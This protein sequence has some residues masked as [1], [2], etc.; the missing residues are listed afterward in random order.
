MSAGRLTVRACRRCANARYAAYRRLA[1]LSALAI[2]AV[3]LTGC[4]S[5]DW[6]TLREAPRTPLVERLNL[7][8][9][10]G[11][12]PTARTMQFLRR[13]DLVESLDG[14]PRELLGQIQTILQRD[15]SADGCHAFAELAYIG[16]TKT[17][18][19][20]DQ[21]ALDLYGASVA[22]SY[23]YLFDPRF[24]QYRNPYD[25]QFRE[26]C[27]LYNGALEGALRLVKEKGTLRPGSTH[28]I[29]LAG[30]SW[31]VTVAVRNGPWR[32]DEFDRFEFVSDYEIKGLQNHY[33]TYGLGV[34]LAAVRKN[35]NQPRPADRYFPPVLAFPMT[36]FL[37]LVPSETG[38]DGGRGVRHRAVLELYD[39][40]TSADIVVADRRVPL[41]TDLSTPLAYFLNDPALAKIDLSTKGL[42]RPEEAQPLTGLYMLEPY[43]PGKIPVLFVHGLWSSPITWMEMF[44][45]L[46]GSP[47]V[48]QHYQFWFYLYPSGQPFWLSATRMRN[49]LMEMRAT[50]DPQRIAP[51]LDQM[52]LVGH[53]MGGLV[54]RMQT[55]DS[56]NDFWNIVSDKPFH[57]VKAEPPVREDLERLFFFEPNQSIRRVVTI[58]T[59]HR[60]SSF[61][62]DTT[63]WVSAKLI[64]LPAILVQ[65][66]QQ[67]RQDNPELFRPD[68][69]LIEVS[70]SIDSLSPDCPILPVMLSAR[71]APWTQYHNIVGRAP[72]RGVVG[73]F[74][75]DGD[76]VVD[77]SSAHLDDV[78][79]EIV[80][81]SDHTNVHRHP[82]ATLE[83]RRVLLE[84]L[85]DLRAHPPYDPN[86]PRTAALPMPAV[87]GG[88][89]PA[90]AMGVPHHQ[91]PP[92]DDRH[93][94]APLPLG[95]FPAAGFAPPVMS[96]PDGPAIAP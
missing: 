84:H 7:L 34:P 82:L 46:A 54:S 1:F 79:S 71:R 57:L 95:I 44:N 11:P 3:T 88:A 60:G 23:R 25:P 83:V 65:R 6:V 41:E 47:D 5:T 2:V 15:P 35:A 21:L 58:G 80:V 43:D 67:I 76:G 27:D 13:Y 18:K 14:E 16:G 68:S 72:E 24:A 91:H 92:A 93:H 31:D 70:T 8:A 73:R 19:H 32:D 48:R 53:S 89:V 42:F 63:R 20:D 77:Y 51:A 38:H 87:G 49:D 26:A 30:E 78:A 85:A 66:K 29:E 33:H 59:P 12:K 39:P 94:T 90:P 37:R 61:A 50:V 4:A 96:M 28:Q 40:L 45:D 56:G 74:A 86:M 9:R 52:V 75:G 17:Q 62:N 36:A 22:H 69:K 10:G 64:S 81:P 55:L